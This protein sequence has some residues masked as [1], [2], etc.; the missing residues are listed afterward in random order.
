MKTERLRELIQLRR[1][2]RIRPKHATDQTIHGFPL[3]MSDQFLVLQEIRE[4]HLDGYAV[5]PLKNIYALRSGRAE[6]AIERVLTGEGLY[7]HINL[8]YPLNLDSFQ[9]L[10]RSIQALAKNVIIET[11]EV[12]GDMIE[13]SFVIGK[14]TGFSKRSVAILNFDD[15]GYW[16]PEPTILGYKQIKWITFDSEYINLFSK[17]VQ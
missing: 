5:V 14:I 4:F 8:P 11:L 15:A 2:V 12:D 7:D 17:Y 16:N 10:F 6:R 1:A 13:E 9:E 3:V